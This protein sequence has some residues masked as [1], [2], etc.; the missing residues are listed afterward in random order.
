VLHAPCD[1]AVAASGRPGGGPVESARN[2]RWTLVAT[3]LGSSLAFVD[4]T[5]VNVAIPSLARD[6]GAG[7]AGA[8]WTIAAYLLPLAAFVLVG[9]AMGDRFGHRR[10]FLAG[11]SL[12]ALASLGCGL[13]LTLGQLLAARA[14]QGAAAALFVPASLALLGTTFS[15]AGRGK[16]IGTWSAFGSVASAVGPLVGGWLVDRWSW[17]LAFFVN[18]PVAAVTIAIM[19]WLVCEAPARAKRQIDAAGAFAAILA[20]GA[21][22]AAL[23]V[24]LER[25]NVAI[26][27][28]AV[29]VAAFGWFLAVE[30][31]APAPMMP[32]DVWRSR[33]FASINALTFVV[34]AALSIFMFALPIRLI[35]GEHYSATASAAALLPLVAEL[36]VLS[37]WTGQWASTMGPRIPLTA[38]A[39]L[40]SAGFLLLAVMGGGSYWRGFLPGI[41]L[42]GLGMAL[43]VAPL[44]TAVMGA[45][46]DARA[47]LASGINNAVARTAG[48][49]GVSAVAL[50]AGARSQHDLAA[51]FPRIMI[52]AAVLA[53][54]GA[55]V[56]VALVKSAPDMRTP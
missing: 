26:A 11:V 18:L 17:R 32:L 34:Y 19:L 16:A 51:A 3:I 45:L 30:R 7:A 54:C 31:R 43:T 28:G 27:L 55:I 49:A 37:R 56:A 46:D 8:Q 14:V 5:V 33:L 52:A 12:F 35:V 10:L 20:L 9:G 2:Q 29:S 4:S 53:L 24:G 48:L 22:T 41:A 23:T 25:T 39:L 13:A 21:M 36:F 42:L 38:G 15:G 40:V 50:I 47:G 44:T 1:T 6:L